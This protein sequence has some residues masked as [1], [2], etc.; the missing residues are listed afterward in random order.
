MWLKD[1]L[2]KPV[3]LPYDFDEWKRLPFNQRARKVCQAWGLQGFGAPRFTV[4]FYSLKILFYVWMWTVFCSFSTELGNTDTIG[5]WWFSL[6]AMGKALLWTVLLEVIGFGGASGPLTARYMPPLGAVTYWFRPGTIKVPMFKALGDS[7]NIIDILLYGALL[8]FLIMACLAPSVTPEVVLP[9]MI[10]LPILGILDRQIY[11]ATRA[12]VWLPA[13]FVFLFPEQI[14]GGLKIV[15]FA[16]WF[17]AAFSKLTPT[18]TS[19]VGVMICNS[20]FLKFNWLKKSLFRNY[21]EDLRLSKTANYISHFGTLVEFS[22]PILLMAGTFLNWP[23]EVILYFLIGMTAFHTFIFMNFPMGVPMEWNVIMVYGGWLL[24]GFHPEASPM[25]VS[26][27]LLLGIFAVCL[28]VLP[29]LGNLFPKYIS[30]LLSMR[31]YAGTWA[32]S[33]WLF[34]EGSKM[35]KLEPNIKKTSPDLRKQLSFFYDQKTADS[36]LSRTISFRMMHLP[37]RILD[38]LIPKAVDNMD[39]YYWLDGEFL[40]G[41]VV[42][43]NFGEGHLHHEPLLESIQKRCN[44]EDGELRVIMVESPQLHN[45]RMHWRI[46][47][48]QEG[49]MEEGYSYIKDQI[50]KMPWPEWKEDTMRSL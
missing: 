21:P 3:A 29:I 46:H 28:L 31:Y 34:K 11:L 32:Y 5:E 20:P 48:A 13:L 8:Y 10:I 6:E 22:L 50:E 40:A 27:P 14:G 30:F 38:E 37:S 16:I 18:F 35:E 23:Q 12:D 9:I 1:F 49:L 36:I 41:E 39:D 19:V 15:W 43:W 2:M 44:F 33:V 4:L 45:G 17:W 42:G 26:H 7:R 25:D 24:F 47:D